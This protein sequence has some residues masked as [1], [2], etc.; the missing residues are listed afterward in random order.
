[1]WFSNYKKKLIKYAKKAELYKVELFS[2]GMEFKTLAIKKYEDKWIDIIEEIREVYSGKLI[3]CANWD[4]YKN[5][6]FWKHLDYIGIDAYFP[7]GTTKD[8]SVSKIKA[9][10]SR[11][12]PSFFSPILLQ[13]EYTHFQSPRIQ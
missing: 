4:S 3:Y 13:C 11:F 5:V 6:P 10:W 12:K 2:L 7:L 8:P 9:G 1:M